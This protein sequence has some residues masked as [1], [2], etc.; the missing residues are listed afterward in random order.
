MVEKVLNGKLFEYC[1]FAHD[2]KDKTCICIDPG[3][4]AETIMR[5]IEEKEFVVDTIF[6]THAHFDH[7]LSCKNIQDKFD[8]KIYISSDDEKIL[9]D[10]DKNYSVIIHKYDF[11]K[12]NITSNVH[13]DEKINIIGYDITCISTPGHTLG[14]M[15]FYIES[16][17]TLFS[18]D[19]LFKDTFGRV[20]LYGGNYDSIRNSIIHKLFLLPDDTIVYPGH[21]DATS[22]GYEKINNEILR[23]VQ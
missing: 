1:Y 7:M 21:G 15:S 8:C 12:L 10:A 23:G 9:Y 2:D 22:I 14:G 16:E 11:D 3:Y 20:D 17:K 19:T 18:G 5:Y 6:L 4:N 13:D